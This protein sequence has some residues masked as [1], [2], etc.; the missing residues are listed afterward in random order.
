M[1]LARLRRLGGLAITGTGMVILLTNAIEAL[2][3]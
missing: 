3:R 1:T 2:A